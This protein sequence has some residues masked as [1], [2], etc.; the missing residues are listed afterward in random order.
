MFCLPEFAPDCDNCL[1]FETSGTI[2]DLSISDQNCVMQI[3]EGIL[4]VYGRGSIRGWTLTYMCERGQKYTYI[5]I[6]HVM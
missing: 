2:T 4:Y 1:L 6:L 5:E 3:S